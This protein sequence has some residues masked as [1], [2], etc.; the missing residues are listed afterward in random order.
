MHG[1]LARTPEEWIEAVTRLG[2]RSFHGK[3]VFRWIMARS[4]M[5]PAE[6]TDIP[7]ALRAKLA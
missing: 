2:G 7:Q 1:P 5:S 4:V 3:Q 6:M